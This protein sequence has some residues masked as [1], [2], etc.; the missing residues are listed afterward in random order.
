MSYVAITIAKDEEDFISKTIESVLNQTVKPSVYVVVD[1]GS[2][3]S[4]PEIVRSYKDQGVHYCRVLGERL[5]VR[6]YNLARAV[7]V[8]FNFASFLVPDW[9]YALKLDADSVIGED[10]MDIMLSYMRKHW[11]LGIMSGCIT[12]RKMWRGRPSDGA[13]VYRRQCWDDIGGMDYVIGWDT[14]GIVKA[15]MLGYSTLNIPVF[16]NEKRTSKRESLKE[17]YL[18]GA[19]RYFLGFPLWHTLGVGV[20]Y[21]NDKPYVI[22]SLVAMLTHLMYCIRGKDRIFSKEYYDFA[23][24]FVLRES[25]ERLKSAMT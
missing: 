14:H 12:D 6:S 9:D 20:L 19:T 15:N 2:S 16:Y 24:L 25:L 22:G 8:G 7:N 1:D 10:Y 21:L 17:W 18:T 5:E 11:N 3:D 23:R 13:K 4:T